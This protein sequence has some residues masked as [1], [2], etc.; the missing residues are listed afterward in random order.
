M[1]E[2]NGTASLNPQS[3]ENMTLSHALTLK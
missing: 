2:N 3:T 1:C